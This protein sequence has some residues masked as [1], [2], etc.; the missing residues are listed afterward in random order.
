MTAAEGS[1]GLWQIFSR[2]GDSG[3]AVLEKVVLAVSVQAHLQQVGLVFWNMA[4]NA[5]IENLT[6]S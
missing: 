2:F 6:K 4:H 3:L 5:Y 1:I